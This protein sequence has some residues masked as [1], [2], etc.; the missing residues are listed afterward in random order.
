M[1]QICCEKEGRLKIEGSSEYWLSGLALCRIKAKTTEEK[2]HDFFSGFLPDFSVI[3]PL[4]PCS[5]KSFSVGGSNWQSIFTFSQ[6]FPL[7]SRILVSFTESDRAQY[8]S[9]DLC[10]FTFVALLSSTFLVLLWN[11]VFFGR[12][13]YFVRECEFIPTFIMGLRY[14]SYHKTGLKKMVDFNLTKHYK[15]LLLSRIQSCL[16]WKIVLNSTFFK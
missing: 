10:L 14:G 6:K 7:N 5:Q 16:F 1:Y 4:S 3:I 13:L 8:W 15:H 2:E 9:Y 11:T 12:A